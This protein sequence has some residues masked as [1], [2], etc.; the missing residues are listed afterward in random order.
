MEEHNAILYFGAGT[1]KIDGCILFCGLDS[2]LPASGKA[3]T[4]GC[5]WRRGQ[6]RKGTV[7]LLPEHQFDTV[8]ELVQQYLLDC[9]LIVRPQ[10]PLCDQIQSL[11]LSS[12]VQFVAAIPALDDA[13]EAVDG[14]VI[15]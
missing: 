13:L 9:I 10:T 15:H 6:Q 2:S 12:A 5:V 11:S 14:V 1:K 8:G 3:F 7:I 4:T